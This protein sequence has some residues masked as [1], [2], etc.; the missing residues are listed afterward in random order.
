MSA[1]LNIQLSFSES[2]FSFICYHSYHVV[3]SQHEDRDPT[4]LLSESVGI[5]VR[6]CSIGTNPTLMKTTTRTMGTPSDDAEE[7]EVLMKSNLIK[8]TP[9]IGI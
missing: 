4:P 2:V 5:A 9:V 8:T 7:L 3:D 1:R 6:V